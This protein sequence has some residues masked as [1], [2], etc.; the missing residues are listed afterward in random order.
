MDSI[1]RNQ[2]TV[3]STIEERLFKQFEGEMQVKL[4]QASEEKVQ[5]EKRLLDQKEV[6]GSTHVLSVVAY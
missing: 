5:V 1:I 2:E 4:A 6:R 3:K